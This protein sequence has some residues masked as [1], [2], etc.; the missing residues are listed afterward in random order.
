MQRSYRIVQVVI[1]TSVGIILTC[2]IWLA[3]F[4]SDYSTH[5]DDIDKYQ[6]KS[7]PEGKSVR[8]SQWR[9]G[10]LEAIDSRRIVLHETSGRG[11]LNV[12][13]SCAVESAAKH[14]P[15]RPIHLF[16]R[17]TIMETENL[18]DPWLPILG[19]YNTCKSFRLATM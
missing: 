9:Q 7:Y 10:Y 4:R 6:T 17:W 11:Y 8:I 12:R 18:S 15:D 2:H 13:Q 3:L 16:M 14:N 19:H 5:S 1:V